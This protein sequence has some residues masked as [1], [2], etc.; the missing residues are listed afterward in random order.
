MG[1]GP[2]NTFPRASISKEPHLTLDDSMLLRDI[3]ARALQVWDEAQEAECQAL[4]QQ[5]QQEMELLNAY[6]SK[7]KI[8]TEAQHEREQQKL[9][10]KVSLRRAHLE[11]KIEEE[12]ASLQKE[13]TD[14]IKHLLDRQEREIDAFDM[15]SLRMGFNNLGAL[16]YP[17]DDYR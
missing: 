11:Q 13:R 9:E 16:D 10:Q 3:N 12:L 2:Q 1:S 4:R 15:E 14:R 17:K 8:Q 6:Q 5:L 7:I